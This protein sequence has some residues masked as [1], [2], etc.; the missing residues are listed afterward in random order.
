MVYAGI[1]S[2]IYHIRYL[3][4]T[5]NLGS[6]LFDS[7]RKGPW[8]MEYYLDR[9]RDNE[10][11]LFLVD[12]LEDLFD[13]IKKLPNRSKPHYFSKIMCFLWNGFILGQ[14]RKFD[15]DALEWITQDPF[16]VHM[17]ESVSQFYGKVDSAKFDEFEDSL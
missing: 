2:S 17:F 14:L 10:K 13:R 8:L 4:E 15:K 7:I 16:M 1:A 11:S 5:Q 9:F 12:I 3:K 6:P